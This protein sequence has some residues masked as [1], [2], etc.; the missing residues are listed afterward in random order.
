ME[1]IAG[2]PQR[3]REPAWV[4]QMN[5]GANSKLKASEYSLPVLGL[6]FLKYADFKFRQAGQELNGKG[7]ERR[8]IGRAYTKELYQQKCESVYHHIFESYYGS[9]RVSMQKRL[10]FGFCR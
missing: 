5:S 6:I 7:S 9:G 10:E 2:K 4:R 8:P 1:Y 3:Y